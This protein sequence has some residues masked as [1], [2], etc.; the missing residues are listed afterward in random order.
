M[1]DGDS[2]PGVKLEP[3]AMGF[4]I[5]DVVDITFT[6]PAGPDTY[7]AFIQQLV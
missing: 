5:I 2:H 1:R 4:K 6:I 7:W 3:A